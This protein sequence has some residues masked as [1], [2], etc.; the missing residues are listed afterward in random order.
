M[1]TIVDALSAATDALNAATA[2]V[3]GFMSQLQTQAS[4]SQ[5]AATTVINNFLARPPAQT[6]WCD[7]VNGN[8]QNDGLTSD[9][10]RKTLEA[11]VIG[12]GTTV[13]DIYLMNDA[14]FSQRYNLN[15]NLRILGVQTSPAAPGFIPFN[16][17]ITFLGTALNS[18]APGIGNFC[19]GLWCFGVSV[20]TDHI[21]FQLPDVGAG[22]D[23]RAHFTSAVGTGFNFSNG[24]IQA[25]TANAG[26]LVGAGMRSIVFMSMTYGSN[27]AGHI[28]Q[29]V[30]AGA[31]PNSQFA[32][33]SNVHSG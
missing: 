23:Y 15:A 6:I 1:P 30:A 8:D 22:Y 29:G 21:D 5:Q 18:P 10:P 11:I 25:G 13:T 28:F 33:V 12:I 4:A 9:K 16:R 7:P 24:I 26:S 32:Y 14:L 3:L 27:A 19:A 31:D 20:T 17:K 2:K